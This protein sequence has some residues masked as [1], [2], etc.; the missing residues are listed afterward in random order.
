M[1]RLYRR[2]FTLD[3]VGQR[4]SCSRQNVHAIFARR[5]LKMRHRNELPKKLV[6]RMYATYLS[7]LSLEKVGQKFGGR[8]A[9]AICSLFKHHD[10]LRR[11][12]ELPEK[13]VREMWQAYLSGLSLVAVA[14]KFG[15]SEGAVQQAFVRRGLERRDR[16]TSLLIQNGNPVGRFPASSKNGTLLETRNY[17]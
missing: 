11:R 17:A 9:G 6:R 1:W 16:S 14:R 2:G 12:N 15:R 10:L 13:R 7:G 3:Q 8:T 5:G 4:F